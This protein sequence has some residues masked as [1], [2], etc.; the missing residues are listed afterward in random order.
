MN[1]I[2]V[3][4]AT[5]RRVSAVVRSTNEDGLGHGTT[6]AVPVICKAM[7]CHF[8]VSIFRS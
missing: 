8:T 5:N 1:A 2:V 7:S 3:V 6:F 4:E